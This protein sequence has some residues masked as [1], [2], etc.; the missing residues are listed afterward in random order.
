[1][2]NSWYLRCAG[3]ESGPVL[4]EKIVELV[5][6]GRIGP[7]DELRRSDEQSWRIASAVEGLFA[8]SAA[9]SNSMDSVFD[10]I[11]D[12]AVADD[13]SHATGQRVGT[14]LE[15]QSGFDSH[16]PSSTEK[17]T[18][19]FCR[20]Q[21]KETGPFTPAE[22]QQRAD[23]GLISAFDRVRN[24][25]GKA[26]VPAREISEITFGPSPSALVKSPSIPSIAEVQSRERSRPAAVPS[27]PSIESV[28]D[29]VLSGGSETPFASPVSNP[30]PKS[31]PQPEPDSPEPRS[32]SRSVAS[33]SRHSA[34][35]ATVMAEASASPI[36]QPS[37][38][39][40]RVARS[41]PRFEFQMP[42]GTWIK[43]L[44]GVVLLAGIVTWMRR[45][46]T[47]PLSGEAKIDGQPIPVGAISFQPMIGTKGDPLTTPI[48]DG[49]FAAGPV[50]SLVEGKYRVR[51]VIGNPL[52]IPSPELAAVPT[53]ATLN[54]AVFEKEIDTT[55]S[56]EGLFVFD[57]ASVDAKMQE[58][59]SGDVFNV[60]LE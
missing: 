5:R 16:H 58:E 18:K 56:D 39:E 20:V 28:I 51:I 15:N 4:F 17:V 22:L 43:A 1:M 19:Y 23:E 53:F 41:D 2:R 14:L 3:V 52:G 34:M 31:V 26:W 24:A 49:E 57:F 35:L 29:D 13:G 38:K 42:G 11:L 50:D 32:E 30:A 36:P 9:H 59:S 44:V 25:D 60:D 40:K 7:H 45:E 54:G 27:I 10:D 47:P 12:I 6:A 21:G 37:K 8:T 55:S 48:I 33:P 46:G